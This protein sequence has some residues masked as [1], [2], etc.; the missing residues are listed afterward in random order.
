M[1]PNRRNPRSDGWRPMCCNSERFL[2]AIFHQPQL[3][4]VAPSEKYSPFSTTIL[5]SLHPPRNCCLMRKSLSFGWT[6]FAVERLNCLFSY[7]FQRFSWKESEIYDRWVT[8]Q[9]FFPREAEQKR[10]RMIKTERGRGIDTT[11][12]KWSTSISVSH[13]VFIVPRSF[14]P[15]GRNSQRL[16]KIR[17]PRIFQIRI[18]EI[19]S[20]IEKGCIVFLPCVQSVTLLLLLLARKLEQKIHEKIMERFSARKSRAQD[21]KSSLQWSLATKTINQTCRAVDKSEH[22]RYHFWESE[23]QEWLWF[24]FEKNTSHCFSVRFWSTGVTKRFLLT[25]EQEPYFFYLFQ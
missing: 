7:V 20:L 14:I 5:P 18:I 3:P 12:P 11:L 16:R 13:C 6:T 22:G 17:F 23:S 2:G 15:S 9:L 25:L 4:Y 19:P 10:W 1:I 8:W 24:S 21:E